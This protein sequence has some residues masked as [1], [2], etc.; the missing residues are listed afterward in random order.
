MAGLKG[1]KSNCRSQ[2]VVALGPNAINEPLQHRLRHRGDE[3]NRMPAPAGDIP[4]LI[5]G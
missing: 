4:K 1:I 5:H 3:R 2:I